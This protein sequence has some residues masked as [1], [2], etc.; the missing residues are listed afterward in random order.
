MG[1][2]IATTGE[3]GLPHQAMSWF[4][5]FPVFGTTYDFPSRYQ[6]FRNGRNPESLHSCVILSPF[7]HDIIAADVQ[8]RHE[9]PEEVALS[10]MA[11][12][13]FDVRA[14]WQV[15]EAFK[16]QPEMYDKMLEPICEL[17]PDYFLI[18]G[19]FY[20]DHKMSAAAAVAY[21]KAFER[22]EDRV[23]MA[24]SSRWIVDY[25]F[26]N[27]RI[28]DA[29]KI[30]TDAAEVYSHA[31]LCTMGHLMERMKRYTEAERYYKRV[32][33]VYEV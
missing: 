14:M 10:Y 9:P 16:N 8:V 26:D 5:D 11:V 31:G 21:Q 17:H 20:V 32:R 19:Q 4:A 28:D 29:L 6:H 33:E 7:E 24:N 2:V 30:A 15:A 22:A 23:Y 12:K 27:G 1:P 13:D 25:Y 18:L 3:R